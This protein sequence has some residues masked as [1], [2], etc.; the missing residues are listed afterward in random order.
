MDNYFTQP[1]VSWPL[2]EYKQIV[3]WRYNTLY[4]LPCEKDNQQFLLMRWIDNG[5]VDMVSTVHT[6]RETIVKKRRKPRETSSNYPHVLTVFGNDWEKMI[7]IP[8]C[9]DDY[10]FTMNGVDKAYQ[11]ISYYRPR[12]RCQ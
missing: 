12:I 5:V 6:G 8:G 9:I 2:Q 11:L 4:K 7:A 1:V 10:N 3:D